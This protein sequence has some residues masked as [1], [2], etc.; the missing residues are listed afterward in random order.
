MHM[1]FD[2]LS[3]YCF[4]LPHKTDSVLWG[5]KKVNFLFSGR[6]TSLNQIR[7]VS[8]LSAF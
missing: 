3:N 6:D 4:P 5:K 7:L 2:E 1:I 8:A